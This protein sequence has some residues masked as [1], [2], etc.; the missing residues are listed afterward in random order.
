MIDTSV[1]PVVTSDPAGTTYVAGTDYEVVNLG[2][3]ILPT[4]NISASDDLLVNYT[5]KAVGKV[6]AI[7]GAQD[8]Y[9]IVLA[10]I[11]EAQA[12]APFTVECYRVKLSLPTSVALIADEFA[13][14]PI[15]GELLADSTITS[16]TESK[17]YR[18]QVD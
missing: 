6:E 17:F 9:E 7:V 12:D 14:L 16:S 3:V 15:E 1:A 13:S 10:G 2:I 11:N 8:E 18:L 5:S 4:G